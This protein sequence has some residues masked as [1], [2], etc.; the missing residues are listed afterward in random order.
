ME[1][2][3]F[4]HNK[5]STTGNDIYLHLRLYYIIVFNT[6]SKSYIIFKAWYFLFEQSRL[7]EYV[8]FVLS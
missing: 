2:L 3:C 5:L 6:K 1:F 7:D 4:A 8:F